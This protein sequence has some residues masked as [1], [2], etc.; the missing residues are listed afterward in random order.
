MG[1]DQQ[2]WVCE[3]AEALSLEDFTELWRKAEV[4]LVLE[5]I[6]MHSNERQSHH[7][8]ARGLHEGTLPSHAHVCTRVPSLLSDGF[9]L[10]VM[11]SIYDL[12]TRS[13]ATTDRQM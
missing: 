9:C 5:C 3:A 4:Q 13:P 2:A 10:I 8:K 11:I 7:T 1:A 6:I 12:G